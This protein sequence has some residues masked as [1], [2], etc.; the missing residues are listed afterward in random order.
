MLIDVVGPNASEKHSFIAHASGCRCV[1]RTKALRNVNGAEVT[2]FHVVDES[3]M[4]I[5]TSKYFPEHRIHV[6]PC[7]KKLL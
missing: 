2:K 4:L 1:A 6:A 5:Q 7:C 3:D